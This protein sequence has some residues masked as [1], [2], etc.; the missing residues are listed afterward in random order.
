MKCIKFVFVSL[1][2]MLIMYTPVMAGQYVVGAGVGMA[3]DYEGSDDTTAVPM[4]VF[5]GEYDSGR[6]FSLLGTHFLFNVLPSK[7]YSFGPALN[8]R[9]E[10]DDVDNNRVDAM[11]DIDSAFEA[12]AYVGLSF[13]NFVFLLEAITDVSDTHN[14]TI[15]T[16]TANYRWKVMSDLEITPGIFAT[17][18]DD[19]YMD[20]YFGVKA[21]NRGLSGLPDYKADGGLKDVGVNVVASYTPWDKWG[22]MGVMSFSTLLNDAKDSPIVD[23]EGNDKQFFVGLMGTY[24]F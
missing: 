10:R 20:T 6:S 24:R 15:V 17:Y 12:G 18:A 23:S 4:L 11:K 21:A 9:F 3:P 16:A 22:V 13:D 8:Y 7:T 2:A 1:F 19:D 14:G 5:N